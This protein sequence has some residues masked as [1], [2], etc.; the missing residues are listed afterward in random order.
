MPK[1]NEKQIMA[2]LLYKFYN[3]GRWKGHGHMS[4]EDAVRG[5]P[6]HLVGYIKKKVI[7]NLVKEGFLLITKHA[8]GIGLS[9][10]MSKL[11]EIEYM[12]ERYHFK[13]EFQ[14]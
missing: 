7:K 2:D 6:S 12:I 9:L 5:F 1:L 14:K 11:K 8:Y 4:I 3:L 13:D 10:N